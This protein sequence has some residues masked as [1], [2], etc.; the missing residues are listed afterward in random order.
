MTIKLT[1]LAFSGGHLGF[2]IIREFTIF[3]TKICH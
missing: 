2:V 1:N 3:Y